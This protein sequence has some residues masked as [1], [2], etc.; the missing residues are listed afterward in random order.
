M[1]LRESLEKMKECSR[2]FTLVDDEIVNEVLLTLADLLEENVEKIVEENAKDLGKMSKSDSLYDRVLLDEERVR[3]MAESVR[4]VAGYDSPVGVELESRELENG[5]ELK[6]V[7]VPFGVVGAIFEARPNVLVDT[8]VLCF[9]SKN[10]CVMKGGSQAEHSNEVLKALIVEAIEKEYADLMHAVLLLKNDRELV[11][12]LLKMHGLV[13]L[14]V[15]R[16][17]QK[18][19][20]FVRGTATVPVIETG[21]GVCHTYVDES[22]DVKMAGEIVHNAKTSRPGVCNALDTLIIHRSRLDDLPAI[23]KALEADEVKIYADV[24]AFKALVTEHHEHFLFKAGEDSFGQEY[25]SLKMSVKVVENLDEAIEH[26]NL[27][28]SGHS[29]AII[30]EDQ[31]SAEKFMN[32]VDAAAVYWNASTRFTDGAVFGLGAELGISTQK[33][34]ARGPMGIKELTSYKWLVR[35]EGQIR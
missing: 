19:I 20:D 10:C 31:Q 35:G 2:R 11:A 13:D 34:H 29:E 32:M 16:G 30:S 4:E 3:G 5:L 9:K 23:C 14:V 33:L 15:P 1:N 22:A 27:Y 12:E 7:S 17:S 26:V 24:P 21:R 25:M 8:F 6:K 18:L 28:G